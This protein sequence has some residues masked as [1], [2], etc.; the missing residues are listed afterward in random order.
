MPG[1]ADV[2]HDHGV[3]FLARELVAPVFER[4]RRRARRRSRRAAGRAGGG[5]RATTSTSVVRTRRRFS[6]PP[7]WSFLSFPARASCR[8]G[9]RRRRPPSAARRT[10]RSARRRRRRARRRSPRRRTRFPLCAGSDTFAATTV[11]LAPRRCASSASANPMRPDERLPTKRTASIGSR[12]PPAVTSTFAAR[13]ASP[14][15]RSARLDR[16][17]QLRRLRQP[18]DPELARRAQRTRARL[19]APSRRARAASR[20]S[21]AWPDART[22]RCSWPERRS[23]VAGTPSAAA[24]SRL[25]AC[26]CASLAS[27][28]ADAGAIEVDVGVLDEREVRERR[29]LGERITRERHRAAG[30]APTR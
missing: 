12:V 6:S 7:V 8:A 29:V 9:S 24:V 2:I 14:P 13:R 21:P 22:S 5:R 23:A 26:P 4:A 1:A 16:R 15:T 27:V 30:P 28:C 3:E 11:T 17:Q 18:A 10:R 19:A 25:S 20:G